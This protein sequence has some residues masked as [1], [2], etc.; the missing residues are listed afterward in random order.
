[1]KHDVISMGE[2]V[3]DFLTDERDKG[4][5]GSANFTRAPGGAPA[6]VAA[7][8]ARLGAKAVFLGKVGSD[9]F[10]SFLADA[11]AGYGVDTS[12]L[13]R[14]PEA[15]TTLF[16]IASRSD[17]KKDMLCYRNPGAD[18]LIRPDEIP[19]SMFDGAKIFH[20]GSLS[21][22]RNPAREAT[23]RALDLAKKRGLFIS[24]DPNYRPTVWSSADEAREQI[25]AAMGYADLVKIADEEWETVTGSPDYAEGSKALIERGVAAVTVTLGEKGCYFRNRSGDG[26][27]PAPHVECIDTIG[28]GDSFTATLLYQ[29][30]QDGR[31]KRAGDISRGEFAEMIRFAVAAGALAVTKRGAIPSLPTLDE[32]NRMLASGQAG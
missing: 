16:F 31:L 2:L 21:L 7:G 19:E 23:F 14:D 4:L 29:F 18:I 3:V 24:F 22:S 5:S 11:L 9:Q 1:M 12:H 30:L 6:N 26:V 10:G 27:I 20:F 32:I 17:G 8:I 28:A 15:L 13:L 25:H